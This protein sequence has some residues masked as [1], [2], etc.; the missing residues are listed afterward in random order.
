MA[1]YSFDKENHVHL[2]DGKPLVGTTTALKILN[3]PGLVWWAAGQACETLGWKNPKK[4]SE[5]DILTSAGA[6]LEKICLLTEEEYAKLLNKAYRAHNTF[7]EKAA[8]KGTDLHKHCETFIK[9]RLAGDQNLDGLPA[10]VL[11]FVAWSENNVKHFLFSEIHCYS[12][13]LWVGGIVDFAYEDMHERWILADIK[14]SKEA[15]FAHMVQMG[16]YDFQLL[17]NG[18]MDM[19]GEV[20]FPMGAGYFSGHAVFHFGEGFTEPTISYLV[21][22]NRR[23][24]ENT[25]ALYKDSEEFEKN[26]KAA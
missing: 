10:E 22:R 6:H 20:T 1:R 21:E 15:Y 17:E 16:G 2:L 9:R 24:F 3:K 11:P 8:D 12:E 19:H 4:F 26:K 25:L 13:R 5:A 23:A 7:K 14:S 18:G